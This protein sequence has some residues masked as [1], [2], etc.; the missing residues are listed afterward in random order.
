MIDTSRLICNWMAEAPEVSW[1]IRHPEFDH[2]IYVS[3]EKAEVEVVLNFELETR[4]LSQKPLLKIEEIETFPDYLGGNNADAPIRFISWALTQ[5][6]F[7]K[8][9]APS[10]DDPDKSWIVETVDGTHSFNISSKA[11]TLSHALFEAMKQYLRF[12]EEGPAYL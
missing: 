2:W 5:L 3:G 10:P 12:K 7:C 8:V 1:G 6:Q 9:L 4:P 11:Q